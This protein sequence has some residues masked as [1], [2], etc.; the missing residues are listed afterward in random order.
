MK[1]LKE[2]SKKT[3]KSA[4]KRNIPYSDNELER[5]AQAVNKAWQA[6]PQIT[7][8]WLT[9]GEFETQANLLGETLMERMSTGST[10]PEFT[11]KLKQIDKAIDLGVEIVKGYLV[12]E[13]SRKEAIFYYP[14]FG[15]VKTHK[16]YK[17]P[18]DRSERK[19]S[20][21][22][23]VEAITRHGLQ[24]KNL[25]LAYWTDIK[26]T[27]ESLTSTAIKID[28]RVSSKVGRKNVLKADIKLALNAL[29]NVL[30]GNYPKTYKSVLRSWGFQKEKY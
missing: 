18:I 21:E 30:K 16:R 26:T 28:G 19:A 24:N 4:G 17:L 13:Y 14:E 23:F 12:G 9:Q 29:I 7:L 11:M 10:R 5:L 20:L 6:N 25:G 3:T 27:Y 2:P 1:K 22:L 15:I 8:V